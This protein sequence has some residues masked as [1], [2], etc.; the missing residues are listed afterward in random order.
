MVVEYKNSVIELLKNGSYKSNRTG[1]D[2]VSRFGTHYSIDVSDD[3]PLLT[4]KDMYW[5]SLLREEEWYMSGEHHIRNLRKYT[6]VWD[7]WADDSGNLPTAYGRFWRKFPVTNHQNTLQGEWWTSNIAEWS[8]KAAKN[9][10]ISEE[11]ILDTVERWVNYD[12]STGFTIDQ[13]QYVVDTLQDKNPMRPAESR[14][15]VVT[16]WH[17]S[18]AVVSKLP[19]CHYTFVFNVQGESLNLHLTQRSGDMALGIPFN[20]GAYAILL[21]FIAKITGY[22]TGVFSHT[23][24]DAHIYCGNGEVSTWYK[25][26]LDKI[27][28]RL[29]ESEELRETRKWILENRPSANSKPSEHEYGYDHIP[30]LLEQCARCERS[31]PKIKINAQ[32]LSEFSYESVELLDYEP[33]GKIGFNVVE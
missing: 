20:L 16:A 12:E 17:P 28:T 15:L 24:C 5:D 2:T 3:F 23:I 7:E 30:G 1:V 25:Q 33:H 27:Q 21:K 26:N 10:N 18:N 32:R 11:K 14:R 4:S 19:P 31:N 6:G 13:L 29:K 8:E 9:Y 22:K